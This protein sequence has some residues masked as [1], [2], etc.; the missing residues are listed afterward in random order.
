MH[1]SNLQAR[2]RS[3]LTVNPTLAS[4]ANH[5]AC[6]LTPARLQPLRNDSSREPANRL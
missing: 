3:D 4:I 5:Q 1:D 6:V 2:R